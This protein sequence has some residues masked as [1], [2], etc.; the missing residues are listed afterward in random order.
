M[1][2][3]KQSRSSHCR[4]HPVRYELQPRGLAGRSS[5]GGRRPC[6]AQAHRSSCTGVWLQ[7]R[8]TVCGAVAAATRH[9]LRQPYALEAA[10]AGRVDILQLAH[11]MRVPVTAEM[12]TAAA[13]DSKW[14]VLVW[15][16]RNGVPVDC[17]RMWEV[18]LQED[19]VFV[20]GA[21]KMELLA[22]L[23]APAPHKARRGC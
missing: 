10:R 15:A 19:A 9:D 23:G 7:R 13:L 17:T 22:L 12:I 6:A 14:N 4:L 18:L 3:W 16:C 20:S 5:A 11:S 21:Q 1:L 8:A 2:V